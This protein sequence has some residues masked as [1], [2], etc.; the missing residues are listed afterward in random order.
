MT[1]MNQV[2]LTAAVEV[3]ESY[4]GR[5]R[6]MGSGKGD[7]HTR[8]HAALERGGRVG[9]SKG[10]REPRTREEPPQVIDPTMADEAANIYIDEAIAD[11]GIQE[12]NA[13]H[14]TITPSLREHV[15]GDG[16]TDTGESVFSLFNRSI[17]GSFHQ[18]SPK[19]SDAYL[20]EFEWRFK[21]QKNPY[22]FRDTLLKLL[23]AK[24]LSYG[25]LTA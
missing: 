18:I 4:I 24:P 15:H 12:R 8:I 6:A 21:N 2:P 25:K 13:R 5:G 7:R 17:V 10:Q 1:E 20:S 22:L 16:H 14:A 9:R 23:E 11:R 3:N 19:H